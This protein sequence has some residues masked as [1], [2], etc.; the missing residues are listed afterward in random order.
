MID[1][2]VESRSGDSGH[3]SYCFLKTGCV[4]MDLDS[5]PNIGQAFR[6]YD[7]ALGDPLATID[8]GYLAH[9]FDEAT[10]RNANIMFGN[11]AG[12]DMN[13]C[14]GQIHSTFISNA[15]E[16]MDSTISSSTETESY[17]IGPEMTVSVSA[18]YKG[19]EAEAEMDI[20][21]VYQ[22]SSSNTETFGKLSTGLESSTMSMVKST[23]SCYE[24]SFSI[25][26]YQHPVFTPQFKSAV[27]DLATCKSNREKIQ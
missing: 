7:L 26:D 14:N 1:Q 15:E 20:P 9:I 10:E 27:Q 16:L 21:P 13:R 4:C 11:V 6:G 19:V 18:E 23:F 3:A 24:Y 25:L 17:S 22:A 12:H 8:H 2:G 5:Y